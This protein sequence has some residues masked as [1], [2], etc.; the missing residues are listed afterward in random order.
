MSEKN[1]ILIRTPEGRECIALCYKKIK[2]TEYESLL[3]EGESAV[4]RDRVK[5]VFKLCFESDT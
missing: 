1:E 5:K 3:F 4:E 2:G